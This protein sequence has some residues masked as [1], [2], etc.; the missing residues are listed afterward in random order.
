VVIEY[1]NC[2]KFKLT[3]FPAYSTVHT[4]IIVVTFSKLRY[5]IASVLFTVNLTPIYI[6]LTVYLKAWWRLLRS[7]ASA[8]HEAVALTE[9]F[10][11]ATGLKSASYITV[12]GQWSFTW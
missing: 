3:N 4:P 11:A 2:L 10:L 6:L 8:G 7:A 12:T 9:A 5:L 1:Y